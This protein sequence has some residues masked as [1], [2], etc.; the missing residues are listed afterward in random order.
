MKIVK[1]LDQKNTT[2]VIDPL[3]QTILKNL[4]TK[5]LSISELAAKMNMPTLKLWRRIQKLSKANLVILTRTEKVGNIEKK[6]YRATATR[7]VPQN[8]FDLKPKDTNLKAAFDIYSDI[9]KDMWTKVSD[10]GDVPANADPTDYALFAS[11]QSF[12]EVCT[13]ATTQAK[14]VELVKELSKFQKQNS[15]TKIV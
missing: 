6:M 7:Y 1:F 13:E 15:L 2:L 12:A 14:L 3:N 9:Q 8:F 4:V 11:M 10:L 5:E